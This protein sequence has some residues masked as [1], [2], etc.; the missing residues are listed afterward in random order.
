MPGKEMVVVQ[1]CRTCVAAAAVVI[2]SLRYGITVL[3]ASS[4]KTTPRS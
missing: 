2:E 1:I 4:A 3:L